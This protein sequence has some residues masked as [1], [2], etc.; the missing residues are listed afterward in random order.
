MNWH[1]RLFGHISGTTEPQYLVIAEVPFSRVSTTIDHLH[2]KLQL[3]ESAT[4]CVRNPDAEEIPRPGKRLY[5]EGLTMAV[6]QKHLNISCGKCKKVFQNPPMI[7][8]DGE[9]R[10]KSDEWTLSVLDRCPTCQGTTVVVRVA[11][12][13][14]LKNR[15]KP[16]AWSIV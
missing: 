14:V 16:C 6:E 7:T 12:T 5:Y 1:K 11:R 9:W 4:E 10:V 15:T 2:K 3:S 13:H 8:R